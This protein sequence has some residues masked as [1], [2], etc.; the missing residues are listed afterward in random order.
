MGITLLISINGPIYPVAPASYH[1]PTSLKINY[2]FNWISASIMGLWFAFLFEIHVTLVFST[3]NSFLPVCILRTLVSQDSY[4]AKNLSEIFVKENS[5]HNPGA[6]SKLALFQG[7]LSNSETYLLRSFSSAHFAMYSEHIL[8]K[9]T[10]W[11]NTKFVL[12]GLCT[13]LSVD[14]NS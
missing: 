5:T 10:S 11:L 8:R 4:D 3:P 9:N 7:I 2:N 13:I 1:L 14:K 12:L 6:G